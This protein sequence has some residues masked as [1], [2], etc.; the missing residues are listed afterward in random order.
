MRQGR[1]FWHYGK[2]LEEVKRENASYRDRSAFLGAYYKEELIGF[3]KM[4]FTE[5]TAAIMQILSKNAHY[6]KRPANALI[7][8]AVEV[9]LAKGKSS[10]TYCKYVYGKNSDSALTEFKRR[11]GFEQALYPRYFVPLTSRGKLVIK[12]KLHHGWRSMVPEGVL[13]V[14]LG[15]RKKIF[16]M[17]KKQATAS[18]GSV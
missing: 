12:L 1:Q 10:L 3:I 15:L 6:D 11:N 13:T 18:T 8:K 17:R 7:A 9:S 2:P 4:V 16:E 5:N 14:L